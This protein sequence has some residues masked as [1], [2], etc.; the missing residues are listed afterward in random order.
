MPDDELAAK[1]VEELAAEMPAID[2]NDIDDTQLTRVG[3]AAARRRRNDQIVI[4]RIAAEY[5]RRHGDW[6]HIADIINGPSYST[7]R[8][9]AE[10][11]LAQPPL[12]SD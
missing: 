6:R 7:I 1:I 9:W 10:P 11:F 12:G 3:Q 4:G 2:W 5:Y 8:R